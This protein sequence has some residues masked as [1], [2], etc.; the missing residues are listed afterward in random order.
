MTIS[1]HLEDFAGKP[2]VTFDSTKTQPNANEIIAI[3]SSWGD[4]TPWMEQFEAL[5][6]NPNVSAITGLVVGAWGEEMYESAEIENVVSAL[7]AAAPKLPNLTALFIGD[8]TYEECEI[9]WIQQGNLGPLFE[10]Y[11]NLTHFGA[12]GG[13]N[14]TLGKI[15]LPALSY[16]VI[17]AGGLDR[18]VVH[19]LIQ[20]ELP[21]LEHF[22]IY[23]GTDNYGRTT[24][25]EDLSPLLTN[26]PF[27]KLR[28]LGLRNAEIANDIATTIVN[29][30]ILSQVEVLDLSLGTLTDL[31]GQ[32]LLNAPAILK[33]KRL[34]LHHHF[35]STE[36]MAALEA[37]PIPVDVSE[38][39][40]DDD[41]WTFVAVGE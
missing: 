13:E 25:I 1:N 27:P 17:E 41:D 30:P 22:E 18:S 32:A 10:A 36:M 2:V 21:S 35:M 9:S 40:D 7:V 19:D 8:I 26:N 39:E 20:S 31:G 11:P 5:L 29:A 34:D 38:Q 37:L 15:T 16:I 28:Y 14:L 12:R 6:A 3:R 4:E 23:I 24:T 33:L